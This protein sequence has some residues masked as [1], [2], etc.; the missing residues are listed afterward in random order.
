[1]SVREVSN[2]ASALGEAIGKLLER[3][4]I[5][6]L[7]D[8]VSNRGCYIGPGKL[9]NGSGTKYQIDGV[10][11]DAEGNPVI[12]VDPKYIRYKK[13]NRDK[14]SW[15]CVAHLNLRKHH[16]S[17]RKSI[18]ILTGRWSRPSV[19]MIQSF[20]VQ[21]FEVPFEKFVQQLS[22]YDIDFD[23]AEKD[24]AAAVEAWHKFCQ[25]ALE[26]HE[27]IGREIIA[28]IIGPVK[29]AV[30]DTLDT[31]ISSMP[32]RI[33]EVEIMLKTTSDEMYVSTYSQVNDAIQAL[34]KLVA[35]RPDVTDFLR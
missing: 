27:A 16:P 35:D 10:V 18:A 31:D 21:V 12:L 22:L 7:Q 15:L 33:N 8:T 5:Q 3:M 24:R 29:R 2:P 30:A 13:H 28:D 23:W 9:E 11:S 19:A 17:I 20:G 25:L 1:M 34:L 6:G 26:D 14:G 4:L 32:R